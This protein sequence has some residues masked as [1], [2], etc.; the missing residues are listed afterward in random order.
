MMRQLNRYVFAI[1]FNSILLVLLVIVG[2]DTLAAII[3]EREELEA[4]YTLGKALVYVLLTQLSTIYEML[5]FAALIGCLAGLGVLAANS[6]LVVM[7][8]AGVSTGRIV[9]MVFRPALV[10]L[11]AGFLVSEY[12]APGAQSIGQS[13]KASALRSA[14]NAVSKEGL[15]HKEGRRY[16]HFSVVQPNGVLYGVTIFEFGEDNRLLG[17]IYA[18]RASYVGER[19]LLEDVRE[20]RIEA[21]AVTAGQVSSRPWETALTPRLLNILVLDPEDLPVSGLWQYSRYL[22]SQNLNSGPYAL[23][24]WKKILQPAATLALV[25]VG[26]CFIFGPLREVTMGFRI[27]IG[28]IVGIVFRTLQDLLAPASLVYG[29]DP[30]YASLV[31]ILLCLG[32][33]LWLL[34]SAR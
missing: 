14:A 24:F 23:A 12:I 30:L 34:R 11:L 2:L 5:P 13:Q 10:I 20:N 18:E 3:A 6:E 1:I 15:W 17:S 4:G 32:I 29:F 26:I 28:V 16:M 19:W 21:T 8:A 9:W 7:R 27:F 31:P 25:L 22:Q 33:G